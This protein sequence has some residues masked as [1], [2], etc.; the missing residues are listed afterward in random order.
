MFL[1][2][3]LIAYSAFNS[4]AQSLIPLTVVNDSDGF[5]ALS[6][7]CW[8]TTCLCQIGT[9]IFCSSRLFFEPPALAAIKS[10]FK[11]WFRIQLWRGKRRRDQVNDLLL[12][13]FLYNLGS[14]QKRRRHGGS[15][16]CNRWSDYFQQ[17]RPVATWIVTLSEI[18]KILD[19][20]SR[21]DAN[22]PIEY[23]FNVPLKK[24]LLW[25]TS[26][27]FKASIN[28]CNATLITRSPNLS[29]ASCVNLST[30]CYHIPGIPNGNQHHG[31]FLASLNLT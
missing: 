7:I 24:V 25:F 19:E 27:V 28:V 10:L 26:Q 30:N 14:I 18:F 2:K 9:Q 5:V 3:L 29:M 12:H 20:L 8:R 21:L 16:S 11:N 6:G 23:L 15:V 31:S 17:I 4:G 13:F 22:G 1:K